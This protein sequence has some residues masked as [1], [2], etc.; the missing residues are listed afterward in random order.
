VVGQSTRARE[1]ANN[2]LNDKDKNR[3]DVEY[4]GMRKEY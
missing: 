4:F 2:M 3:L 1:L